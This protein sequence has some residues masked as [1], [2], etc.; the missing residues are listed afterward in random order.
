MVHR[1][2][3]CISLSIL[4]MARVMI[5]QW[6]NECIS[7]VILPMVRVHFPDA[8]EYFTLTNHAPVWQKIS[9]STLNGTTQPL[10]IEEGGQSPTRQ[11]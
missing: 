11:W 9:R 10:N 1:E 5:A 2:N 6:E 4:S 3:G 8:S 7:L